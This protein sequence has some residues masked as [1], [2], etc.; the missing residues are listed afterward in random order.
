VLRSRDEDCGAGPRATASS[1]ATRTQAIARWPTPSYGAPNTA[2]LAGRT[3]G[4]GLYNALAARYVKEFEAKW[5]NAASPNEP[6]LG[7]PDIQSLADLANAVGVVKG[8]RRVTIGPRLLTVMTV[9]LVGP[10]MPLFLFR[11][12][13]A[14]LAQKFFSKLVGL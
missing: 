6:L 4:T 8:M 3:K 7:T 14:E 1:R 12:P 5:V 9:T 11:Y 13:L 10:L 2:G